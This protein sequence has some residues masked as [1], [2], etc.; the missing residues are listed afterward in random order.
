M[1]NDKKHSKTANDVLEFQKKCIGK[2]GKFSVSMPDALTIGSD[3]CDLFIEHMIVK[4]VSMEI[5]YGT[6]DKMANISVS[7]ETNN[8]FDPIT[9]EDRGE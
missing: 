1:K 3:D 6:G 9:D 4:F 2:M 5:S 7:F 8:I